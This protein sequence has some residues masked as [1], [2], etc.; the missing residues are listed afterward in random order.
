M[1]IR[2][3]ISKA[4]FVPIF[5]MMIAFAC[6]AQS[7]ESTKPSKSYKKI[8]GVWVELSA[9]EIKSLKEK[10]D[11][12]KSITGIKKRMNVSDLPDTLSADQLNFLDKIKETEL[13]K[14]IA[15]FSSGSD[16]PLL[17]NDSVNI[18]SLVEEI[19]N[20]P[21]NIYFLV[22]HTNTIG[23]KIQNVKLAT[24]RAAH[25]IKVLVDLYNLDI[26]KLSHG[27]AGEELPLYDNVTK[28]NR[29]KNSRAEIRK[30]SIVATK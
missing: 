24:D 6:S 23:S 5:T 1:R 14:V 4:I 17:V 27:G 3:V 12:I 25:T 7:S 29:L 30:L 20:S 11:S 9:D 2:R 18:K 8:D 13:V 26:E 15:Q 22:G 19:N 21:K 28:E 10:K 16:L